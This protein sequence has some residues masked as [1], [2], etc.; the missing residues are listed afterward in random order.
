[1]SEIKGTTN[2]EKLFSRKLNKILK[3]KG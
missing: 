2:F 3:K 1:M